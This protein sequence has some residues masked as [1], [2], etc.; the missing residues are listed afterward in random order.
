VARTKILVYTLSGFLSSLA[1]VVYSVYL[2]SGY[3]L[4]AMMLELDA[5]AAVV[6]GGT[7]LIGGVG[8]VFGTLFGVLITGLIQVLI[9]FNGELSSWWTRI[10]IGLLTLLFI[11]VQ[12][13]FAARGQRRIITAVITKKEEEKEEEAGKKAALA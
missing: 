3:G 6:I 13:A 11:G 7:Q 12:S 8:Y 1:G 5:I 9:M 2:L 4:N 10:A